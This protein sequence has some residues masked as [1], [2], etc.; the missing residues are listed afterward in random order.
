MKTRATL[1]PTLLLT[2]L[3]FI[4][5]VREPEI[6]VVAGVDVCSECHMVIDQ[7]N[8]AAGF[9]RGHEFVTFDSPGCLLRYLEAM[10]KDERP[11]PAEIYFADYRTGFLQS[12][13][14]SAFLLTSHIPTVMNAQVVVFSDAEGAM[15]AREHAD[16]V[17][18]D[19]LGY[20]TERGTPD[21]VLEVV[22]GP[23]GMEP[24]LVEAGKD[25]LV[26]LRIVGRDLDTDITLSIRGYPEAGAITVPS[27]GDTVEVRFLAMKPGAGF[28]IGVAD[29][30]P[31][32]MLRIVGAHTADEAAR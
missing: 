12:A 7:V 4:G 5:C 2:L 15:N 28:P 8:Q 30:E 21:T 20:R 25:D 10:P 6:E 31:L 26:Q 32:G 23:R 27:S 16:E 18:T 1:P 13:D 17:V 19:W 22:F 3:A 11:Q 14:L 29:G 9:V 24:D